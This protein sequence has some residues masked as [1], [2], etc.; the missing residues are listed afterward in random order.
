MSRLL[1][2]ILFMFISLYG[3]EVSVFGAGD[4]DSSSPYGLSDEEKYIYENKKKLGNV[5]IKVKSLKG[6]ISLLSERID[7]LESL[8]ESDSKKLEK[9]RK[10]LILLQKKI[11]AFEN[12]NDLLSKKTDSNKKIIE[13]NQESIASIKKALDI[14]IVSYNEHITQ[15]LKDINT[16]KTT[17]KT[18]TDDLNK[19]NKE[20]I[21][22]AEVQE[23]FSKMVSRDEFIKFQKKLIKDLL[24]LQKKCKKANT[25]TSVKK[26]KKVKK[27]PKEKTNLQ[28]IEE[29]RKYFKK[30]L[31]SK[32]LPI[33]EDLASKKYRPAECNYLLG[34]IHYYRKR[35]KKAVAYFKV[36]TMLYDKAKYMP[37]LL[38]HSAIS[39][40]KLGNI[41][42]ASQ[43]YMA[44]IDLY[45]KSKEAKEAK[46]YLK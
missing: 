38:L 18:I 36:S 15:Y 24:N 42:N 31:F 7:G 12:S 14:L 40:E 26:S 20:Y 41:E 21:S 8:Y 22:K 28:L 34:E 11:S 13:K 10:S 46:K 30:D 19:I 33:L 2:I 9:I 25:T 6:N 45:P 4:I 32:A 1:F 44:V 27:Q 39:F 3:D 23:Q 37:K 35:Y 29:A 17:L 16:T 5:D 43:F